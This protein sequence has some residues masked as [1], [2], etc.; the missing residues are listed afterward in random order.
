MNTCESF[1]RSRGTL[2]SRR[3]SSAPFVFA[4]AVVSALAHAFGLSGNRRDCRSDAVT[5]HT[6]KTTRSTRVFSGSTINR[7]WSEN[8]SIGTPKAAWWLRSGRSVASLCVATELEEYSLHWWNP[9]R[10]CHGS[11]IIA[12]D[13]AP[14]L[15]LSPMCSIHFEWLHSL[16]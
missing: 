10:T 15:S 4:A 13:D 1:R 11:W 12:F 6:M 16:L 2:T 3:N 8:V 9:L 14:S 5:P 7:W